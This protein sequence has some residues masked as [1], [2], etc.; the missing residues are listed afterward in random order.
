MLKKILTLSLVAVILSVTAFAN[1][2]AIDAQAEFNYDAAIT[3]AS[4]TN[5]SI[6]DGA[7]LGGS[8]ELT[9]SSTVAAADAIVVTAVF[10]GTTFLNASITEAALT[11]GEN[12]K[13][14]TLPA[15]KTEANNSYNVKFFLWESKTT[16]EPLA[17]PVAIEVVPKAAETVT[18]T[19]YASEDGEG[20]VTAT[21]QAKYAANYSWASTSVNP[22]NRET[23][24]SKALFGYRKSTQAYCAMYLR[25]PLPELA[26]G[27]V[28]KSAKL[29]AKIQA[30]TNVT[31][32]IEVHAYAYSPSGVAFGEAF[33]ATDFGTF[34]DITANDIGNTVLPTTA[35]AGDTIEIDITQY[36]QS[37]SGNADIFIAA[38]NLTS[39]NYLYLHSVRADE[40]NNPL[41]VITTEK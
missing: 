5:A 19:L 25:F 31:S 23:T 39:Q 4:Q 20:R 3:N 22:A 16:L 8:V 37:G 15:A 17:Q 32:D 9:I 34:A 40:V 26:D 29:V 35:V 18:Y 2:Y 30:M 13:T 33:A 38:P 28:V 27:E 21:D 12:T 24:G 36:V 11:E 6:D 10:D 41:L 1:P 14:I 7:G